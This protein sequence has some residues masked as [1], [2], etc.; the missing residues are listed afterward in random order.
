MNGDFSQKLNQ[1][2]SNPAMMAQIKA[3]AD[4]MTESEM[5]TE[6]TVP[7]PEVPSPTGSEAVGMT[8]TAQE[9]ISVPPF[10]TPS[11]SF[12]RNMKNTC[13]LL[14][15]LK[16]FLDE[17]RRDKIDKMLSMIRFAQMAGQLGNFF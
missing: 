15:A 7:P 6:K 17:R 13:A 16:P 11:P 14:N 1:V 4:T 2:L 12:E 5:Q 9:K 3:L 8:D 10:F